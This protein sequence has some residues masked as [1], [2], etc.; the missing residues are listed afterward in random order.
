MLLTCRRKGTFRRRNEMKV[1][2]T[3]IRVDVRVA[4]N[5]V[6]ARCVT[7]FITGK[8]NTVEYLVLRVHS[9]ISVV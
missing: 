1:H 8:S 2:V 4:Y 6:C 3:S 5:L 7:M 9:I